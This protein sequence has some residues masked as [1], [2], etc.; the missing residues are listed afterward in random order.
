MNPSAWR[1][2]DFPVFPGLLAALGPAVVWMALAQGSGELIWWPH[3]VAKYGLGF[4]VLLTPACFLQWPLNREIGRYTL[5]TGETLYQGF[6]RVSRIYTILIWVVLTLSFLWFGAFASAGGTA[7]AALTDFPRGWSR[8]AQSLFWGYFSIAVFFSA[9]VFS[10]VIY[11]TIEIFMW[12]VACVTLIG[13]LASCLHPQVAAAAPE[14]F[15][16]LFRP[17]PL[18]RPWDPTD[19]EKVLTAVTF[20]G[21]GGFWTTFYSYWIR[22]KGCGMAARMGRLS[23]IGRSQENLQRE[24][25]LPEDLP[26][27]LQRGKKWLSF[28]WWDSG[29]GV[30]GNW[31]TTLLT[32][33]LAF[34]LLFPKG[35][36]PQ[37][38]ELASV[39]AEFFRAS[40]GAFGAVLFWIVAA[41]FLA[42]TWMATVDAVARVQKDLTVSLIPKASRKPER[43]WYFFYLFLFTGITLITMAL[44]QPGPLIILSAVLGFLGTVLYSLGLYR[45]NYHYLL[46]LL[47]QGLRPRSWEK[48]LFLS[49]IA[50]YGALAVAYL[51]VKFGF[52]G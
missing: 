40:W 9:L 34:A 46:P 45:L 48:W 44:A 36:I 24:G 2:A 31:L 10:K 27:N 33:L 1:K 5:L 28:L 25:F 43:F 30:I 39:Q 16:A 26:E 7:L 37:G 22:E 14:F 35:L 15:K 11:K 41:A 50:C 32:A 4:L 21:L 42:D 51:S 8:G 3:L 29:V 47:P 23:G 52:L 20:A 12:I 19:A 18:A 49:V 17:A 6:A 13:L 38:H